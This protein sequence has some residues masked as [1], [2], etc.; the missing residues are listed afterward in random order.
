[1]FGLRNLTVVEGKAPEA[2]A[3]LPAPTH[4]FI[5]GSSGNLSEIVDVLLAK[6]PRVRVVVSAI[7]VETV[8]EIAAVLREKGFDEREILQLSVARGREA[9]RYHLM[10][11]QNPIWIAAMQRRGDAERED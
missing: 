10:S 5:G 11:G 4:A 9:G 2:L 7:A 1:M 3:A 8:G 6:N